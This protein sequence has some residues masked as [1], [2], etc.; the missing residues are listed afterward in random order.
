MITAVRIPVFTSLL[1]LFVLGSCTGIQVNHGPFPIEFDP[2]LETRKRAFLDQA[3][4]F[5]GRDSLPNIILILVD[6]LGKHDIST[7]DPGGVPAPNIE[8]LAASGVTYTS[9]YSTS[10][11]CSPSRASLM[12]GRYQHRFG[13]ERQPMNRY[14]RGKLE[15]W[16]VD[17]LV[18]TRPMQLIQPMSSPRREAISKQGIPP[19]EILLSE[20]LQ[21]MGYTTGI[22]GKWHLG[23]HPGFLPNERGFDEQFGFYEAFSLYAHSRE[24]EMVEFRHD[25]FANKH[26]WRQKRKG[27]CAIRENG[28]EIREDGYL[29]FRIAERACEFMEKHR[30]D[31][32]FLYIPFSAPHTPFQVPKHY[33]DRFPGEPDPNKRVYYGMI[34]ALDDAVGAVLDRLDSLSLTENTLIIFASDN[35]GATYTGATDNGPLKGGKFTQFEG[36]INIPLILAWEGEVRGG[37]MVGDPVSLLD[38]FP[39]V[40]EA[41]GGELPPE[42]SYDGMNLL[43]IKEN[44]TSETPERFLFWRTDFNK[45][46]RKGEWKFIWN[47]RDQ[48]IYLYDLANDPGERVNLANEYPDRIREFKNALK[49]WESN[50]EKASWPGVMEILFELDGDSTRWAI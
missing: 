13:F 11:V 6:D 19:G 39:T 44:H 33:Y 45:A 26:I 10:S 27:S 35:G 29:T 2:D 9:A 16:I 5:T 48:M 3:D 37:T 50:M 12:T 36:G 17:H 8:R 4:L 32:F 23:H 42:R 43:K 21:S 25:Y 22:F 14:P 41:A 15:Y 34:S 30:N 38:L 47:E 18:D 24:K 31:P 20:L 7:Y 49:E 46:A 1:V 40:V 28:K